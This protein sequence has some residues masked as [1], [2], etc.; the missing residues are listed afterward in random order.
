MPAVHD[1]L[2]REAFTEIGHD[3]WV[4]RAGA[5]AEADGSATLLLPADG[6]DL[7]T[8]VSGLAADPGCVSGPCI[9]IDAT[10]LV[11]PLRA[12]QTGPAAGVPGPP[13]LPLIL[14]ATRLVVLH[15]AESQTAISF[16]FKGVLQALVNASVGLDS[17]LRPL[18]RIADIATQCEVVHLNVASAMAVDEL[19]STVRRHETAP[20]L[21]PD[22]SPLS[23]MMRR[24]GDH[25]PT[26]GSAPARQLYFRGPALDELAWRDGSSAV[27]QDDDAA[28]PLLH[29]LSA[30]VAQV[31]KRA[32]GVERVLLGGPDAA[33]DALLRVGLLG[34]LPSWRIS[35]DVAW[36]GDDSRTT[37]LGPENA[38]PLALQG[39]SHVVWSVLVERGAVRQDELVGSCA[40][41]FDVDS[42][43]IEAPI[44][45][46]LY[47]LWGRGLIA[48][49]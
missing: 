9:G 47:D 8:M 26:G 6:A 14:R 42:R 21:V 27:L 30:D 24:R 29:L 25:A 22:E 35:G 12:P 32:D 20:V 28:M 49:V 15:G 4:L 36:V 13:D 5:L 10:G 16:G 7:E 34:S 17:M 40:Q 19:R 45:T 31:W 46:L 48:R 3:V 33:V 44:E 23:C 39:S 18:A 1:R 41:L 2:L 11:I 38:S 43:E 37:V